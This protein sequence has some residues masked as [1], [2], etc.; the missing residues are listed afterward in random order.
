MRAAVSLQPG[1]LRARF[2]LKPGAVSHL[3]LRA[4]SALPISG[5][6]VIRAADGAVVPWAA[7]IVSIRNNGETISQTLQ[8]AQPRTQLA[9]LPVDTLPDLIRH[10]QTPSRLRIS[11]ANPDP[12]RPALVR[13]T[14]FD[15]AGKEQG[16]YEQLVAPGLQRVW[17]LPDLFN[18]QQYRGSVRVWSDVPVAV[19]NRR[20]TDSLGGMPVE[21]ELGILDVATVEAGPQ[22]VQ[23][24]DVLDGAGFCHQHHTAQSNHQRADGRA[25]IHFSSGR[26]GSHC[27]AVRQAR[28][29][30]SP[31]VPHWSL[32]CRCLG[33]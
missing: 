1:C 2:D 32:R 5:Y 16:R 27:A 30:I 10:G 8:A 22:S 20:E 23:L 26:A 13:F 24:P 14:L 28:R 15:V 25:E 29:A 3:K 7:G 33:P 19:S 4:E 21:S 31:P 12:Q 18:V 17:S 11:V 9:W 6:A